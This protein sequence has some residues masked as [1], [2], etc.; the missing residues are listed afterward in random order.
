MDGTFSSLDPRVRSLWAKSGDSSWHGLLAHMLDVAAT[1]EIWLEHESGAASVW[2]AQSFGLPPEIVVRWIA[3]I[4]GLHDF[5]PE[6]NR[7]G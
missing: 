3:S 4:T 2:V 7:P 6:T 1:S 5:G